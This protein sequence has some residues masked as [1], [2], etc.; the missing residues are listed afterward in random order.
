MPCRACQCLLCALCCLVFSR[1][2]LHYRN[3]KDSKLYAMLRCAQATKPIG[4]DQARQ[5]MLVTLDPTSGEILENFGKCQGPTFGDGYN[6]VIGNLE[7]DLDGKL[8]GTTGCRSGARAS[9]KKRTEHTALCTK[10]INNHSH[11]FLSTP[12]VP[13][14]ASNIV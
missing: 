8:F 2:L 3:P 9:A 12:S 11:P 6:Q 10:P 14:T 7:I 1:F 13:T 4:C 5:N